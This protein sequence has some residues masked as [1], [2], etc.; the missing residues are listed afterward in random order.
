MNT[1]FQVQCHGTRTWGLSDRLSTEYTVGLV[2][3]VV[4]GSALAS[5]AYMAVENA[6]LVYPPPHVHYVPK[7]GKVSCQK[8]LWLDLV[9]I[10]P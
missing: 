10:L 4:L 8:P 7:V 5:I 9:R 2:G 1:E 6:S 3:V